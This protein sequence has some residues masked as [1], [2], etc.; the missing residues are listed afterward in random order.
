MRSRTN[1]LG[2]SAL[3]CAIIGGVA[4]V[5]VYYFV[6]VRRPRNGNNNAAGAAGIANGGGGLLAP[7]GLGQASSASQSSFRSIPPTKPSAAGGAGEDYDESSFISKMQA[8]NRN[9]VVFYGSQT[10]TA[11]DFAT[12]LSKE[13][14][15]YGLRA[16]SCDPEECDMKELAHLADIPNS[17]AIFCLATYGE[18][19]PTD[20]LQEFFA[21]LK[22]SDRNEL[23]LSGVN[24][25]V[26][27]LGNK[28][29]E[30]YNAIGI[31]VDKKLEEL[32]AKRIYE[33]GLGD[34]DAN[35]EEDFNNWKE[36]MWPA[37][38]QQLGV[39]AEAQDIKFRQYQL[40]SHEPGSVAPEKIYRGEISRL[41][42]LQRQRP[43]FDAKNPYL[44]AV[45][46]NRELHTGGDRS[47]LHLELDIGDSRIRYESGDHVAVY[48]VNRVDLVDRLGE[49]L[50]CD[51][52]QPFSLNNVDDDSTKKHPFPCPTT[53]RIAFLHYLDITAN[54]KTNL[55]NELS[56]YAGDEEQK[57]MLKKMGSNT[58]EG[59]AL[60]ND[61]I[62][63]ARRHI[64]AVLED[65]NSVKP[66]PDHLCEL[67]PRLQARYYSIA[68]SPKLH[69]KSVHVCAALVHYTT[70]TSREVFGVATGQFADKPAQLP[71]YVRRSQFRLPYKHQTPIIMV[72]PGTG[73]APF[74]GFL[75]EREWAAD[76]G[77]PVGKTIL[78]TGC[79]N[80]AIDYIYE[81]ELEAWKA[82]GVISNLQVAF[83]RDQG[84]KVY[85]Q[86]LM[87]QE[88]NS[89]EI[90]EVLE[91]GGHFYVCGDAKHMARDVMSALE[92]IVENFGGKT[93]QEAQDYIKKLSNKGR[94]SADVWS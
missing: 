71:V 6:F 5:C 22:D 48:P 10:G 28:T 49:L 56:D 53:Y 29:Y 62:I 90:W 2:L 19:D 51:L 87:R 36:G 57:L 44:A 70:P 64:V 55:L 9:I 12:R 61:W 89:R 38:C 24:Y 37:A 74:R 82:K 75:Q 13:A 78:Y 21:M 43:P 60:Y 68:S 45:T 69:P 85:V 40:V 86:H 52:D 84:A 94:Y 31:L 26:F 92:D 15:R 25:C 58:E 42:S 30:H 91:A 23:D 1:M 33:L 66:P 11:E 59:K 41:G 39:S 27:G 76:Q 67:L 17:L 47:C 72:G 54:P 7:P 83:S 93:R 46:A 20:N 35:I 16:M 81:E 4:G 73:F 65:L 8:K 88:E 32:G 50:Q 14:L 63:N 80:R 18:G 77:K 79:R 34:D 3:D